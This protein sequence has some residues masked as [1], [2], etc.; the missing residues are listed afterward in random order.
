MANTKRLKKSMFSY[1]TVIDDT[2]YLY[3]SL[4]GSKSL[5]KISDSNMIMDINRMINSKNYDDGSPRIVEFLKDIE[6]IKRENVDEEKHQREIIRSK[7][8]NTEDLFLTIIPTTNCN[9][10]CV[11]CYEEYNSMK[12]SEIT[13]QNI[14]NFVTKETILSILQEAGNSIDNL[15]PNE[16]VDLR[17]YIIDSM[18]FISFIISV[19][20]RFDIEFP[21][22]MLL[23]E[24]I[25]SLDNFAGIVDLCIEAK[26]KQETCDMH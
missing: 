3:N 20:E 23:M 6:F 22:E 13:Q 26:L 5:A 19:E 7:I 12:M 11:Y 9:F 2:L 4:K 18:Q 24:N 17:L 14:I 8:E 10:K 15:D 16:N 1:H 25:E 21:D